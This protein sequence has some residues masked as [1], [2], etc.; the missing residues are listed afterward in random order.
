MENPNNEWIDDLMERI[1]NHDDDIISEELTDELVDC[2]SKSTL[3]G[4]VDDDV[5]IG[6]QLDD[7][8]FLPACT[9]LDNFNKIFKDSKPKEFKFMEIYEYL[10]SETTGIM[11]NPATRRFVVNHFFAQMVFNRI[12]DEK[13]PP[14]TKGY[15]VKVRL[16][17]LR[18]LTWR[19]LIIPE[20]ITFMELD[21]ILKTLWGFN[22]DHLSCFLIR[23]DNL[24]IIDKGLSDETMMECD[25]DADTTIING[26]F[27]TYDKITYWYDFGDDWQ[28]DIEIKKTVDYDKKYV[29]IKRFKGKY[30][31]IEDC[32]GIYGLSEIIYLAE[33]PG[34][35]DI[36][37]F[38]DWVEDLEEFDME[39]TQRLLKNKGYVT[40]LWK[41]YYERI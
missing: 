36:Y 23:K 22:G 12:N 29:T 9:D 32:S 4:P 38:E 19:D 14:V 3:I 11:I 35:E 18:P 27:E 15:D 13:K 21:D 24:T 10:D 39:H 8:I 31:P 6:L 2:L 40:S 25:Y 33:N 41:D 17:N 28:F 37:G 1:L 34:S 20:N 30:N 26:F 7:N 5:L 16:N